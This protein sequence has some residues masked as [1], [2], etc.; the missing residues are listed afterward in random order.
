MLWLL[1]NNFVDAMTG[2]LAFGLRRGAR[3]LHDFSLV[4]GEP[5]PAFPCEPQDPHFFYGSTGMLQRLRATPWAAGLFGDANSLDQRVWVEHRGEQMLNARFELT[6]YAEL[7]AHPPA[8]DFFVRPVVDQKSF[9][10][11][12]VRNGDF[13]GLHRARKG[14]V[15]EHP[16]H[17]LL[18]I[19]PVAPELAAEYRFIVQDH[20]VRL[21]SSYR[22]DGA[23]MLSR[24]VPP[25]VLE[26]AQALAQGW[27]PAS[28]SVMDVAILRDGS[29]RI[30]EFNAV[31]SSG[32]YDIDLE[33]FAAVVESAVLQR[34]QQ[35]STR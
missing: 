9:T 7:V 10:G 26:Q 35:A 16:P 23:Q 4:P 27:Q 22:V 18:A 11:Q 13:A 24:D 15:R 17:M 29:A 20:V 21:G 25:A 19:S 30:V 8:H 34:S 6:T 1:Q 3:V 31:H 28:L 33:A 14:L 32:L 5:L 12:V 2:R